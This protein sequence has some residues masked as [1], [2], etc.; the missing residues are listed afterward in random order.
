MWQARRLTARRGCKVER[1]NR[2]ELWTVVLLVGPFLVWLLFTNTS[3]SRHLTDILSGILPAWLATSGWALILVITAILWMVP[4]RA[5]VLI[6]SYALTLLC[7]VLFPVA[8]RFHPVLSVAILVSLY[9][10]VYSL[11][12]HKRRQEAARI[13]ER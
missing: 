12:S 1:V 9:V 11:K 3:Y 13:Q 4:L 5:Y 10:E 6:P 2:D 7:C 8:I